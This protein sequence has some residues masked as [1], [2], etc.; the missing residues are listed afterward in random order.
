MADSQMVRLRDVKIVRDT[1]VSLKCRLG[2]HTIRVRQ[3]RILQG[4][5]PRSCQS[6]GRLL[7]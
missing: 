4:D 7:P 3:L 6:P 5:S 1:A 2:Y